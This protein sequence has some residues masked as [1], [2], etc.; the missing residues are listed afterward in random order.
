MCDGF[1]DG[2]GQ[3]LR[4]HVVVASSMEGA[5]KDTRALY[6]DVSLLFVYK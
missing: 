3:A 1:D 5:K 2:N 6:I 4:F